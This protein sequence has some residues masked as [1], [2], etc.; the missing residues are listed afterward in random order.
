MLSH[1]GI[2]W[3]YLGNFIL[4]TLLAIGMIYGAYW[5]MHKHGGNLLNMTKKQNPHAPTKLEIESTLALEA[6]KNLYVV[7]AGHERFLLAT[8]ME[9]TQFL[10]KLE[11]PALEAD[12]VEDIAPSGDLSKAILS[13]LQGNSIQ[14]TVGIAPTGTREKLGT[15]FMQSVQ[16][17]MSSRTKLS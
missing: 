11:N 4:Y 5:L 14:E 3:Q 12:T 13:T 15:R 6:R 17:L 1:T 2:L 8:T 16:W 7:K 9:G 10:S